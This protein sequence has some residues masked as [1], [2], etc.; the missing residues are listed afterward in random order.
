MKILLIHSDFIEFEPKQKAIKNAEEWRKGREK[1]S[2]CLVAFTSVERNDEKD[3]EQ[4]SKNFAKEIEKVAEE[5]KTN[6]IV[7]YPYAHL[8]RDLASPDAALKILKNAENILKKRYKT[9]RAP[10]GW[11]K[12]FTIKCKGHPL[13]ELSRE[14]GVEK[15][16]KER[17]KGS[18][19]HKFILIDANGREY[20]ITKKDWK[21][22][23]IWKNKGQQYEMLN[24]FVRNELEGNPEERDKPKH[25]EY[26][27]KLELV[28]YCPESDVGNFKW[29]PKGLLIKDLIL[30]FQENLARNYGAFK[31]QNPI[32]YRTSDQNIRKLIGEFHEKDYRIREEK[33]EFV[34]RF[35]S[36]PG[37][38]PFMQKL[39]F[40]Y[41]NMPVKEYEEAICFRKEQKGEL[42][43]LRRVRNFTMTDLHAFCADENQ[44]KEE[45]RKLCFL[46]QD[47]MNN[48]IS[49]RR[50]VLGWEAVESF[51]EEH[52]KWVLGLV[53]ELGVPSFVKLMPKR[54]H[55]YSLKNEYQSIEADGANSQISTVQFDVVNGERFNIT[56]RGEDNKNYPCVIIHCSTFGSIERTLCSILEN[57][58]IDEK[59]KKNPTLPLWLS[60]TQIRLCPV[61]DSYI[62]LCEKIADQFEE[63]EIRVDVDDRTE[64][65]Q[66]KIMNA[67]T[68][69]IPLILVIGEKE[70][71]GEKFS[72]RFRETGKIEKMFF[73]DIV[74]YIKSKTAGL[75]Y[76]PLP[77]DRLV[78]KRPVFVGWGKLS[79][80]EGSS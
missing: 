40:S 69:W 4:V 39:N 42:C 45:F 56:Y 11:Y 27:R 2:D 9:Y 71:R 15:P 23:E 41:K 80:S 1:I 30:A 33:E 21:K 8:G 54:S 47:L 7:L 62:E 35:A 46:C 29:Y 13:S 10:F 51:Y 53:K 72:V 63:R 48:I 74:K 22:S 44:A 25:I 75:P 17:K 60:P 24:K 57:A 50:W 68:E 18:E 65:V 64:S 16:A 37:A 58:A 31:I 61:S 79:Q 28:D 55:Y 66:K 78:S 52:K 12:A 59:N 32:I 38:F 67:E 49:K 76:K 43:G 14:V 73:D 77:L 20:V 5:V 70:K 34:L 26:M 36:D 6:S 3:T 19:F